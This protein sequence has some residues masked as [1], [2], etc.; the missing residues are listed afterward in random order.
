[1]VAVCLV[2]VLCLVLLLGLSRCWLVAVLGA[3]YLLCVW[4]CWCCCCFV[5]CVFLCLW[6]VGRCFWFSITSDIIMCCGWLWF[7]VVIVF[8]VCLCVGADC[9]VVFGVVY[10]CLLLC[11]CF[12]RACVCDCCVVGRCRYVFWF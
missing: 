1:M 7:A 10:V 5:W 12:V 8:G 4:L 6:C 11:L 2:C 3:V 9:D